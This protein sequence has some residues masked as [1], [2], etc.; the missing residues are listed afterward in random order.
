[1]SRFEP[2]LVPRYEKDTDSDTVFCVTV[3][4]F[5]NDVKADVIPQW[6]FITPNLVNDVRA[7]F[8]AHWLFLLRLSP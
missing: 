5:A 8:L 3:N 4:D 6:N 2:A 7:W 1:M